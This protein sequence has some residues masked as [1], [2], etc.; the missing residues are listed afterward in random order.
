VSGIYRKYN[1]TRTDG[2]SAPGGKHEHCGYFVLDLEHDEFAIPALLAYVKA[3]RK[4][5]PELANDILAIIANTYAPCGC[6]E[7]CCPHLRFGPQNES[8]MLVWLMDQAKRKS[9]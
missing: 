2:S 8:E 6:R 9:P 4:T 5:K 1:V 3:C 7:A